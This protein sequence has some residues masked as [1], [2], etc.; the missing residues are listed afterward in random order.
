MPHIR[1]TPTPVFG[2]RFS[3]AVLSSSSPHDTFVCNECRQ[4]SDRFDDIANNICRS[5][6]AIYKKCRF[7][8]LKILD[9]HDT[10]TDLQWWKQFPRFPNFPPTSAP[11]IVTVF[12][13]TVPRMLLN[14]G[15]KFLLFCRK[16]G[17]HTARI[18]ANRY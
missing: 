2:S 15:Q 7:K 12:L 4:L 9:V 6:P 1:D 5:Q 17:I 16:F 3:A 13:I 10:H 18:P 8:Q 11:F 14:S